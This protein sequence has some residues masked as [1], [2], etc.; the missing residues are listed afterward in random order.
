[1]QR[2][3]AALR[4]VVPVSRWRFRSNA[5][6]ATGADL[7]DVASAAIS[8]LIFASCFS[9]S[10]SSRTSKSAR[11]SNF[12]ISWCVTPRLS[13]Q[14]RR[15]SGVRRGAVLVLPVIFAVAAVTVPAVVEQVQ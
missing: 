11:A 12:T 8:W 5:F 1:M 3:S 2:A 6:I 7:P 15:R 4:V 14:V 9:T 10:E 13:V